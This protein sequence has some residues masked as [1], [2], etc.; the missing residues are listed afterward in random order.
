MLRLPMDLGQHLFITLRPCFGH[1]RTW[2]GVDH[3][4]YS[5]KLL[6]I[7]GS[8]WQWALI[9]LVIRRLGYPR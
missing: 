7:A 8:G 2:R 3:R 9:E 5:I 1:I 6:M 4:D